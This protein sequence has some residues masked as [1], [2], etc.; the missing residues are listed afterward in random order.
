MGL[1]GII[2]PLEE[3]TPTTSSKTKHVGI[4]EARI[5]E[6]RELRNTENAV[7]ARDIFNCEHIAFPSRYRDMTAH[8]TVNT[9]AVVRFVNESEKYGCIGL[10][11]GRNHVAASVIR[12]LKTVNNGV[13]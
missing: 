6:G 10:D 9:V 5:K 2:T 7:D 8:D 1:T 4:E 3:S 12:D 13:I 11:V